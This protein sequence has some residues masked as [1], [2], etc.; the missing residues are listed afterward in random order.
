MATSL[1]SFVMLTP[2]AILVVIGVFVAVVALFRYVS[3]ASIVAVVAFP[4]LVWLLGYA[5]CPAVLACTVA[6]AVLI[7]QKH[8][9]NIRRLITGAE[10][11]F[12][13]RRG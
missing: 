10:P 11:R 6:L 4:L 3:L 1:G 12:H 5:Q 8:Q 9:S 2:K 13:L 7:V